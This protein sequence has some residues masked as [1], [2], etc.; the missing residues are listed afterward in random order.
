MREHKIRG[1]IDLYVLKVSLNSLLR[2]I[3]TS[4]P[5]GVPPNIISSV[6]SLVFGGGLVLAEGEGG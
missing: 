3:F 2:I 4:D 5:P 6:T 1:R